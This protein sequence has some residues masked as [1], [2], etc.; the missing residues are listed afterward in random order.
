MEDLLR[1]DIALRANRMLSPEWTT[2]ATTDKFLSY[3]NKQMQMKYGYGFMDVS[4]HGERV[5]GHNGGFPG[6][7]A[8]L[9]MY[10]TSGYTLVILSNYDLD[11]G[12]VGVHQKFDQLFFG[13]GN[14]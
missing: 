12:I 11:R 5:I 8:L 7:S 10:M 13:K 1:F 9:N 4:M 3:G 14:V 2:L 6:V